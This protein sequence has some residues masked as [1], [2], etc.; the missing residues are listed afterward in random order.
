MSRCSRGVWHGLRI[1]PGFRPYRRPIRSMAGNLA[2]S[3]PQCG[4]ISSAA[5]V[6]SGHCGVPLSHFIQEAKIVSREDQGHHITSGRAPAERGLLEDAH[7]NNTPY[8][9]RPILLLL[10]G[11]ISSFVLSSSV[12]QSAECFVTGQQYRPDQDFWPECTNP[13][14][15]VA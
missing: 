13:H 15:R 6:L 2:V 12:S 14:S 5:A 7:S 9:A 8:A 1:L 4:S 3:E 10:A 11:L